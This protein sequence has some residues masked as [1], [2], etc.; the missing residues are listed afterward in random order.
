M[1][2]T[3][4]GYHGQTFLPN[5]KTFV[6]GGTWSGDDSTQRWKDDD[7]N[8][9]IYDPH[10][11]SWSMLNGVKGSE[12]KMD[13]SFCKDSK[14]N[15]D[16]CEKREWRQHHPW[17][18]A[19]KE[20]AIFHGGPSKKMHWIYTNTTD[21]SIQDAGARLDHGDAVCAAVSMYDAENGLT[22]VA[23]AHPCL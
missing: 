8:G 16:A 9:E 5:G 3:G 17:L 18:Y 15:E 7:R 13:I 21:G 19:W 22:L 11:R 23:G 1:L 12:I 20:S 6:I 2:K 4:R 10:N 14:T